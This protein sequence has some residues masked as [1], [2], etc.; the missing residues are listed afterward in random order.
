MMFPR[1][2][3]LV[4]V[5]NIELLSDLWLPILLAAIAALAHAL[6]LY[7]SQSQGKAKSVDFANPFDLMSA[8]RFGFLY[9]LVLL[10]ARTA[11]IYFGD[12]GV[13]IASAVSGLAGMDAITLSMSEL[14][15]NGGLSLDIAAQAIV[16]A[17]LSNTLA[18][19]GIVFALGSL[20]LRKAVWPTV[21]LI[22]LAGLAAI[23]LL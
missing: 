23:F 1:V 10:I 6:Y 14:S 4:G 15:R 16:I 21:A 19:G 11:Q 9:A 18:K 17:I 3:V 2:L 12:S 7:F 20:E 8:L 5:I 13:L 22:I